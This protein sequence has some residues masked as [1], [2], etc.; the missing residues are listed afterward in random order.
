MY[1]YPWIQR[2]HY[3][4]PNIQGSQAMSWFAHKALTLS[5][6]SRIRSQGHSQNTTGLIEHLKLQSRPSVTH[7]L[8]QSHIYSNKAAFPHSAA[9]YVPMGS[10]SSQSTTNPMWNSVEI[11]T[12]SAKSTPPHLFNS[13]KLSSRGHESARDSWKTTSKLKNGAKD[14]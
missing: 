6:S 3:E 1:T 2:L 4:D 13:E 7:F 14:T 11:L 9:P 8:Q 10:I 5:S 12:S